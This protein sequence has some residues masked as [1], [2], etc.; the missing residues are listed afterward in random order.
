MEEGGHC[1]GRPADVGEL[2]RNGSRLRR[3]ASAGGP[4]DWLA[5]WSGSAGDL[6][7]TRL[8]ASAVG[9]DISSRCRGRHQRR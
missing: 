3:W 7:K 1:E 6:G 9:T 5:P 8:E 2:G 4:P